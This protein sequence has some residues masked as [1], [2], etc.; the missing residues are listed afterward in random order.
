MPALHKVRERIEK[1]A[2]NGTTAEGN[3]L[4]YA[5]WILAD[6]SGDDAFLAACKNKD[7]LR[8]FLEAVPAV[9]DQELRGEL[10][11]K[12]R[13]LTYELPATMNAE[14][15]GSTLHQYGIKVDYFYP[16]ASNVAI[17][18]L[19]RMKP[20]DSGVV[21]EIVM[22]VPQ[23]KQADKFALRFTGM[24]HA[25]RSGS[26]TFY[27][28]S[29][30]GSRL[31]IG[32]RL[33][34]NNDG[35]HSMREKKGSINM[36][37]GPHPIVVTYFDNGGGDGLAVTWQ[38]PGLKKQKISADRLTV[39]G[40]ETLHDVA[41]RALAS[42]PGHEVQ[43]IRDLTELVKAG[44]H[45]A[46]AIR[47]LR[48]IPQKYWPERDAGPLVDNLVG[49]LS[50]IPI[51]FRTGGPAKDA[52]ALAKS[53][54]S[55][56]PADRA[57]A[58]LDRLGNL[59]VRV[60][61]IGTVPHRMIYDKER[62]AVQAGKPV[63]FR[64]SNTDNMPH[65]FAITRP[66][67]LQE[68]GL[69][70][71]ATA[72]D[73]DAIKRH[74]IPNSDKILI[75]SRLLQSG[76][77]QALSFVAPQVPGIYP[78]VCTYPGHWRRMYGALYIVDN[79]EEYQAD[80][81]AYLAANPLSL[82]DELLKYNTRGREWKFDELISEVQPLPG[83]RAFEV[84]RQLFK[85]ANCAACHR[86]NNEGQV[87]GSDLAKLDE[88]KSSTEHIL[89]SLLEPSRDIDDKYRSYTFVLDSGKI[90]TGMVMEESEDVVKVVIDPIAKGKP[91]VLQKSEIEERIKSK[92][93]M[94]PKGLLDKLSREEILDLIAYVYARGDKKH[95]LFEM[96]RQH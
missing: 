90:V 26:Y 33:V 77:D 49:Y 89:R 66:G 7:R 14:S 50:E 87:F 81:A 38:G 61:A 64:F 41:I 69:L 34:V 63:E 32:D 46:S 75:A 58:I 2:V 52:M 86:L 28:R 8:A 31:Y 16:S 42:I 76:Q 21:P 45:R 39:G 12:V 30:D 22:D 35:K 29:D 48:G 19:A 92:I 93:S 80:P 37:A 55:K 70:G 13:P 78:Y 71:E 5:A 15:G 65:N 27:T 68:I 84:G 94:M 72:R 83:E 74:Y 47:A 43:K 59:N 82:M 40:G 57:K 3:R 1:L 6:G 60:I 11:A 62:I 9:A 36:P 51:Q 95:K 25:P 10:Y 24:I 96:H 53:L 20:K 54:S 4:G 79:L 67:A 73:V 88:K 56:L 17:E 23:R 18:T 85:V 91:S 44:K